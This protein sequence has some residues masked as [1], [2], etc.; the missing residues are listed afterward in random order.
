[1]TDWLLLT[2]LA[3]AAYRLWHLFARDSIMA[4][5]RAALPS[6]VADFVDCSWCLGLWL[7]VV[8][9]V[10]QRYVDLTVVWTVL[11]VSAVVGLLGEWS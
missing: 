8:V 6:G 5:P 1:M 9:V 4:R 10:T 2:V 3:L 11:A 7:S